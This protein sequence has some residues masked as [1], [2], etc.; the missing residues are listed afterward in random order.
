MKSIIKNIASDSLSG[1]IFELDKIKNGVVLLNG[2]T[3]CKLYNS[4]ISKDI[5]ISSDDFNLLEFYDKMNSGQPSVVVAKILISDEFGVVMGEKAKRVN[6]LGMSIYDKNHIGD[7]AEIERMLSS[8]GIEI[9]CADLINSDRDS[10]K[11]MGNVG[12]NIVINEENGLEIAKYLKKLYGTEFIVSKPIGFDASDRF[13]EEVCGKLDAN[14]EAY[15]VLSEKARTRAFWQINK[16]NSMHGL[17]SKT[18][19][20][21]EGTS[22]TIIAYMDFLCDYFD[23]VCFGVSLD[24]DKRDKRLEE[25]LAERGMEDALK[26]S[27]FV[28]CQ[29]VFAKGSTIAKLKMEGNVF[30]GV[31]IENPSLG[32]M[33]VVPKCQFGLTGALW[34]TEQVLNG[35][36]MVE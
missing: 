1:Y 2:P 27:D 35:A 8:A 20:G 7:L 17:P 26:N 4:S 11:G 18:T 3:E 30:S 12:L 15:R 31:E 16:V 29:V 33:D 23:M 24:S 13:M 22:S 5:D 34:I 28:G 25:K 21:V 36:L 6:I 14:I 32:Y 10:V 19:F 9:N